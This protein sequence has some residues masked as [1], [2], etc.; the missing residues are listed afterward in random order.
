[1]IYEKVHIISDDQKVQGWYQFIQVNKINDNQ[2]N[3]GINVGSI[4]SNKEMCP[5]TNQ[6]NLSSEYV[7]KKHKK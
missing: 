3:K 2:G 4:T 6:I 1:M 7:Y 5:K